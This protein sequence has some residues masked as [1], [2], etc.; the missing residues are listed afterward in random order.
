MS[1]LLTIP[2]SPSFVMRGLNGY[3]FHPLANQQLD[4]Y[5][6]DVHAGH[7]TFIVSKTL[8]RVY[9]VL[10]GRGVF[11]IENHRYDVE[12]GLLVEV[13]PGV[14]YSYSG[15]MKL[16]AISNPRWFKGNDQET[17]RNPDVAGESFVSGLKSKISSFMNGRLK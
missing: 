6:L 2:S 5:V 8:T 1:Y 4:V 11:V 12:A 7:D 3:Q 14:E 10:E 17:R 9:Y 13:P 16:L 15:V